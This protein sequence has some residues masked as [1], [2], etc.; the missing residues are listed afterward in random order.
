[1]FT[2]SRM[3]HQLIQKIAMA[4]AMLI[5]RIEPKPSGSADQHGSDNDTQR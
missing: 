1:M 5:R 4:M 2:A 3:S